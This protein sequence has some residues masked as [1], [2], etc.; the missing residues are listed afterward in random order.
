MN[1]PDPYALYNPETRN[2]MKD[3]YNIP[4]N[5]RYAYEGGADSRVYSPSPSLLQDKY[6]LSSMTHSR[7]PYP[8]GNI[9]K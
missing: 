9:G 7:G 4:V 8:E 2:I 6:K 1:K 3:S 5:Q